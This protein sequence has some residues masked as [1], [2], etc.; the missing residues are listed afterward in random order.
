MTLYELFVPYTYV[1][2]GILR[3]R[4]KVSVLEAL[5]LYGEGYLEKA[6]RNGWTAYQLRRHNETLQE[7]QYRGIISDETD[8]Y[9]IPCLRPISNEDRFAI[10]TK[11]EYDALSLAEVKTLVA[12][13]R[14]TRY[15][16]RP[17]FI[18]TGTQ[19]EIAQTAGLSSVAVN[20]AISSLSDKHL[21]KAS[22]QRSEGVRGIVGTTVTLLCPESGVSLNVLASFYADRLQTIPPLARY[23][24]CLRGYDPRFQLE[25]LTYPVTGFQTTCPFCKKPGRTLRFSANEDEDRWTCFKCKRSGDSARLWALRQWKLG[26]PDITATLAGIADLTEQHSGGSISAPAPTEG[27]QNT[28]N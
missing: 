26:R 13:Y 2:S 21:L 10:P 9:G 27:E 5:R 24:E 1:S 17:Y 16:R 28:W 19:P 22:K 8:S 23:K 3:L 6:L 18:F 25:G 12:L 11:I 20:H 7:L 15:N 14:L 4:S